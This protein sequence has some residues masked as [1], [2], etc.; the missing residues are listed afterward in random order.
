MENLELGMVEAEKAGEAPQTARPL[1]RNQYRLLLGDVKETT[2]MVKEAYSK[3]IN[4]TNDIVSRVLPFFDKITKTYGSASAYAEDAT[5]LFKWKSF[6]NLDNSMLTSWILQPNGAHSSDNI[7]K[8]IASPCNWF[9]VTCIDGS[10]NRLNLTS[11]SPIPLKIG[12]LD[13]LLEINMDGKVHLSGPIP[14]TFSNLN[15]LEMLYLSS[16]TLS[17]PISPEI[18]NLT[19]LKTL[20]LFENNLSGSIPL[21]LANLSNCPFT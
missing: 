11:S 12:N 13:N 14:S 1:G 19:S 2:Q 7:S 21:S 6:S 15:K 18:G 5:A 10:V 3:P 8:L 9:G 4:F 17:G 20:N 16:N